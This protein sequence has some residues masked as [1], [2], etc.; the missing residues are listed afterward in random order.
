MQVVP[1][2]SVNSQ[3]SALSVAA[4]PG[5]NSSR[6]PGSCVVKVRVCTVYESTGCVPGRA[7][8][9]R[10]MAPPEGVAASMMMIT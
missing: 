4:D 2:A 7:A 6:V 10:P 3:L 1:V 5:D 9:R 8:S